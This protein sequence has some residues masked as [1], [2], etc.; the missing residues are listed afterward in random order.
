MLAKGR[1]LAIVVSGISQ[2]HTRWKPGWRG[3]RV[4]KNG[5][6]RDLQALQEERG[7]PGSGEA[8]GKGGQ[9]KL[10]TIYFF[11][12]YTDAKSS[13]LISPCRVSHGLSSL[14]ALMAV[15]FLA[16]CRHV[17]NLCINHNLQS[18]DAHRVLHPVHMQDVAP[19]TKSSPSKGLV[20]QKPMT[21]LAS[22][23]QTHS[24][25][26]ASSAARRRS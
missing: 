26:S 18:R 24:A 4:M 10:C 25:S 7:G 12:H 17:H 5:A 9:L 11:L 22:R 2:E 16:P 19:A 6:S 8:G 20:Q 15:G 1:P 14:A 21:S 13:S 3:S 23:D